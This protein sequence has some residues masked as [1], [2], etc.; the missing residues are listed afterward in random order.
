MHTGASLTVQTS[1]NR[2]N[3]TFVYFISTLSIRQHDRCANFGS[4]DITRV[5]HLRLSNRRSSLITLLM[6]SH[7]LSGRLRCERETN[8][9][10][11]MLWK[12]VTEKADRVASATTVLKSI[13]GV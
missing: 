8:R 4:E 10:R 9:K 3:V 7:I 12:T 5:I 2:M 13:L 1:I 11:Q 6:V